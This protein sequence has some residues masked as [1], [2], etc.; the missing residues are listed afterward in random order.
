MTT[1]NYITI[2][3]LVP[4]VVDFVFFI[5]FKDRLEKLLNETVFSYLK[6]TYFI[7]VLNF[8]Q[9]ISFLIYLVLSAR[10]CI[11][12]YSVK[13]RFEWLKYKD[14]RKAKKDMESADNFKNQITKIIEFSKD[15]NKTDKDDTI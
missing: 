4:L 5:I 7:P 15:L 13:I 1:Y 10:W 9:A 8:V 12:F 6:I 3:Y 14:K 11:T 2:F